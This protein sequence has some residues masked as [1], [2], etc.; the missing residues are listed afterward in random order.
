M[1]SLKKMKKSIYYSK[2]NNIEIYFMKTNHGFT[3]IVSHNGK[4]TEYECFEYELA[5][6]KICYWL[7]GVVI[8][9]ESLPTYKQVEE[10]K[11]DLKLNKV[12][13]YS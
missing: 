13:Y 6:K 10:A 7:L 2:K 11:F 8:R 9:G 1:S 3:P 12:F 4:E 5:A